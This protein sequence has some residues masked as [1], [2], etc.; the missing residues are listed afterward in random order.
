MKRI[1]DLFIPHRARSDIFSRYKPGSV[2]F[3]GNGLSDNAVVGLVTPL[4]KDK[5]FSFVG[6]AVSAFCEATVQAPPFVA[7]GRAGNGLIVLEARQ[8]MTAGNL[9]Y[10]AAYINAGLRWRFSWYWQTTADRISRLLVPDN[11]PAGLKFSVAKNMPQMSNPASATNTMNFRLIALGSIFDVK[12]G[13]YHNLSALPAG[14]VPVVSCGDLD[15]GVCGYF[16][17]DKTY[18]DKMTIA[19]NGSTLA[20]KY[21]P[22]EFAA[23]DDVAVCSPRTKLKLTTLLFIQVMLGREQWRFNYYRKCYKEKLERVAVP[24]PVTDGHIDEVAIENLMRATPYWDFLKTR[25]QP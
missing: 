7:C 9:A 18:H 24:L 3:I 12:G 2:P 15:N 16:E 22:Y 23:K 11:A 6:I 8:A 1:D 17:V 5:V 19:F 25:L 20:A 21:H 4:P 13:D 10:Y 14:S